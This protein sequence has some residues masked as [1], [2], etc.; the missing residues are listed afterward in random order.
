MNVKAVVKVMNF[1]ALLHVEAARREAEKYR[2][3]E[4]ELSRM[5][6]LILNNRNLQLDKKIFTVN[7]RGEELYIYIG[8]D[9]GFCGAVN[10]SVNGKASEQADRDAIVIGKK[11][12]RIPNQICFLEREKLEE[13]W[14]VLEQIFS[15]AIHRQIYS[16]IY[17]VYN[18]YHNM[19]SIE[20][21]K[22]QIF[23]VK[24]KHDKEEARKGDFVI[25]G[26]AT[27]MLQ[28]MMITYLSFEVGMAA[29]SSYA[30]E[31]ISRRNATT[32]S[33][34]KIDEM[35]EEELWTFRKERSQKAFKK[36]IDS[37]IKK[38]GYGGSGE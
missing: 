8:S 37:F 20:C 7:P 14:D 25:T 33:L 18:H 15:D 1:H 2:M 22:R 24:M 17:L 13:N 31:N 29:V 26:D 23:P 36:V 10:S 5:M 32:D 11:L 28:S 38:K 6:G 9:L 27:E 35:E 4:K 3:L 34:K 30:S 19:T 12:K 16:K 21:V